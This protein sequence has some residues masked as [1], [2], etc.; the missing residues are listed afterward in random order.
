MKARFGLVAAALALPLLLSACSNNSG[1]EAPPYNAASAPAQQQ[2]ILPDV[3]S[4]KLADAEDALGRSN[5]QW[6]VQ[7]S[8][9]SGSTAG[10]QVVSQFPAAGASVAAG[11][12]V[13][14][15]AEAPLEAIK[16]PDLKGMS[17]D[18]A[19]NALDA[20]G[21]KV[22]WK[23]DVTD[24]PAVQVTGISPKVGS[25]AQVGD[26]IV[27]TVK[28]KPG[29]SAVS[30]TS[31]TGSESSASTGSTSSTTSSGTDV[32]CNDGTPSSA[33]GRQG[34]CSGHGGVKH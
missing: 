34:A 22:A 11:T 26:T 10:W 32:Q 9:A 19:Q 31:P 33:G 25:K 5:L 1:Q 14:L 2:V 29:Q 12:K 7:G 20:L 4:M 15:Y 30:T 13:L 17:G 8:A 16:V 21:L 6:A 24:P 28:V 27:L 18:H 3:A 23:S